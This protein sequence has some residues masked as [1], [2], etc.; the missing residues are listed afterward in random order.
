MLGQSGV[1]GGVEVVWVVV[2]GGGVGGNVEVV[3]VVLW[4]VVWVGMWGWCG[5]EWCEWGGV[6]VYCREGV[7]VW[8]SWP[9][10]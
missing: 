6:G 10:L 5:W 3:W 2:W 9:S 8:V 7:C 1:G 4:R